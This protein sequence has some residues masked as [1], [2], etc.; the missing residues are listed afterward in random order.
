MSIDIDRSH[1]SISADRH[2]QLFGHTRS[3]V[4]SQFICGFI[5]AV[6]CRQHRLG[7]ATTVVSSDHQ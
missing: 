7:V 1:H 6:A 4:H 3:S 2:V 5:L